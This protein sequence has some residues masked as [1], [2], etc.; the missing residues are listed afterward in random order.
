MGTIKCKGQRLHGLALPS[1]DLIRSLSRYVFPGSVISHHDFGYSSSDDEYPVSSRCTLSYFSLIFQ[2]HFP[3][4]H[5]LFNSSSLETTSGADAS[6]CNL[7][8]GPGEL[9]EFILSVSRR[10]ISCA[11]RILHLPK[12]S[13]PFRSPYNSIFSFRISEWHRQPNIRSTFTTFPAGPSTTVKENGAYFFLQ[14]ATPIV[15]RPHHCPS[16]HRSLMA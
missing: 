6:S 2:V 13:H 16:P 1:H 11:L 8:F 12:G 3:L 5:M 10:A 4:L 7:S 14:T 9:P 15:S